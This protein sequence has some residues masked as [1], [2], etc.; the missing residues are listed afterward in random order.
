MAKQ[1]NCSNDD[2]VKAYHEHCC[3]ELLREFCTTILNQ[4]SKADLEFQKT[5]SLDIA[6]QVLP[7]GKQVD[8][9]QHIV[10]MIVNK[11]GDSSKKVQCHA[12]NTMVKIL[13]R[14][15]GDN[16]DEIQAVILREISLFLT[17]PGTKP[18]HRIYALGFLNKAVAIMVGSGSV[19]ARHSI[20]SIY[21]NLFNQLLHQDPNGKT[22]TVVIKKDR[23]VSKQERMKQEKIARKK[24]KLGQ[25]DEEDNKV[26]ELVLK[27]INVV[28]A[29]SS[30]QMDDQLKSLIEKQTN[31]LFRLTHHKV[32]RIQLQTLKLLFQFAKSS[33]KLNAI[34]IEEPEEKADGTSGGS[35]ADRYY[36]TLYEVLLKV[37]LSKGAK[38]DE[39]F[40]LVFRAIKADLN[41]KRVT[42]YLKRML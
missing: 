15:F 9:T 42:A 5:T 19:D 14:F 27:G 1:E 39:Y 24:N 18:S 25:V 8:M 32:F 40:G 23:K 17:R 2:I 41:I 3:R 16:R 13:T 34:N 7:Y 22:P 33:S 29:K 21:F 10:S 11:F 12:I 4:M 28:M 30:S 37:H 36:R 38:L 35:F 31:L 20:L 6:A 26:I